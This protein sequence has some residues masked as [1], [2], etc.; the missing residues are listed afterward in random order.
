MPIRPLCTICNK[1]YCAPNY[2]SNGV[3]HYRSRCSDC[4]RKNKNLRPVEP[5]W[6]KQGYKKKT[7]CDLCG[8]KSQ[9]QSQIVVYHIDGNLNNCDLLN[10][11]SICLCCIEIV[12][13][14]Q[15]TWKIGDLE[16]DH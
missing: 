8:F 4:I 11:R 9:Y 5:R 1:N 16:A 7:T 13:R 12:K 15:F 10:L 6:R 2:Y 3:R 14:K